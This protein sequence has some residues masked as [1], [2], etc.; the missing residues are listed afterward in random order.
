MKANVRK[1]HGPWFNPVKLGVQHEGE[2]GQGCQL[3]ARKVVNAWVI[4]GQVS[5]A[6]TMGFSVTYRLLSKVMKLKCLTWK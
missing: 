5:P 2:P 6:R 3:L 1:M 4:P